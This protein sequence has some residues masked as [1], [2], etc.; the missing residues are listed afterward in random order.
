M[1]TEHGAALKHP[2]LRQNA[3][4]VIV[5]PALVDTCVVP[6]LVGVDK[7]KLISWKM[8]QNKIEFGHFKYE[9]TL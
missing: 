1:T 2:H 3:G 7:S 8:M 5:I 9:F 6:A 4:F